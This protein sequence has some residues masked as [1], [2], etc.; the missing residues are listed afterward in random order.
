MAGTCF[1]S[2]KGKA[3]LNSAPMQMLRRCLT[4][5]HDFCLPLHS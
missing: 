2:H 1:E 5:G 3:T 4:S